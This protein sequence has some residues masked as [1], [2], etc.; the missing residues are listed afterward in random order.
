MK[1]TV[2]SSDSFDV[3][4]NQAIEKTLFDLSGDEIVFYLWQNENAV[5]IGKNQDALSEC[6][7]NMFTADGGK[8]ARRISGGGAVFHDRGNLNFTFIAPVRY[9]DLSRQMKVVQDALKAFGISATLSGRNDVEVNGR[10]IS[11]NAFYF[12]KD[13]KLHHGTLLIDVDTDKIKKY[14]TPNSVKLSKKGVKSVEAR[15]LNLAEISDINAESLKDALLSALKEEY[16]KADFS[17]L[18]I[19]DY[20]DAVAERERVFSD[21]VWILGDEACYNTKVVKDSALGVLDIRANVSEGRVTV[22]KVYSDSLDI[23]AVERFQKSLIGAKY[24]GGDFII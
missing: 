24:D 11:G 16:R 15:V 4:H 7:Y 1:L 18:D 23:I 3:Y 12:H 5:V 2:K 14:L 6:D 17:V 20:A 13:K 9:Y 8:V 22:A 10:K 21:K 19:N